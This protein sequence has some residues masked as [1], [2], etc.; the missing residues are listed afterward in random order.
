LYI[1]T[2]LTKT[3]R[4]NHS[5]WICPMLEIFVLAVFGIGWTAIVVAIVVMVSRAKIA[6][7]NTEKDEAYYQS[8]PQELPTYASS[9][10]WTAAVQTQ[11]ISNMIPQYS[12][13][14]SAKKQQ[15]PKKS[16]SNRRQSNSLDEEE[17][18]SGMNTRART[19]L[20]PQQQQQ[21]K[22]NKFQKPLVKHHSLEDYKN[23]N[24]NE[25][26]EDDDDEED[27]L[28]TQYSQPPPDLILKST[29]R[30]AFHT[31]TTQHNSRGTPALMKT[32]RVQKPIVQQN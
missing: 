24:N 5:L 14:S 30:I 15:Q 18:N 1:D 27:E 10:P 13:N 11:T 29:K 32:V 4:E 20:P 3:T 31:T 12:R 6:K 2:I 25:D 9:S 26:E 16:S 19:V 28:L 17:Y 23:K 8:H 22:T 21:Q 7:E